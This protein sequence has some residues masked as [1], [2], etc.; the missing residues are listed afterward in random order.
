MNLRLEMIPGPQ[1]FRLQA[2]CFVLCTPSHTDGSRAIRILE[3]KNSTL[4]IR[5]GEF[6]ELGSDGIIDLLIP[7]AEI[8][9]LGMDYETQKY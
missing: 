5:L 4:P 9:S 2:K 8:I 7:I 1:I 6:V 3:V